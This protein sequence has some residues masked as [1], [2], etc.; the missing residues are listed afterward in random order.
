[1]KFDKGRYT[2]TRPINQPKGTWLK[3][4]KNFNM[5]QNLGSISS[6]YGFNLL[7]TIDVN[8]KCCG[9]IRLNPS[10]YVL[11]LAPI[12]TNILSKIERRNLETGEVKEVI[13]SADLNFSIDSPIYGTATQNYKN[14]SI[15]AFA[16]KSNPLR[17]INV[18]NIESSLSQS[19]VFPDFN[20]VTLDSYE[21]ELGGNLQVGSYF[22]VFRYKSN[23][24]QQTPYQF[25][26]NPIKIWKPTNNTDASNKQIK[27]FLTNLDTKFDTIEV[28]FIKDIDGEL[29]T[30][31]IKEITIDNRTEL[32]VS[33]SGNEVEQTLL[34]AEII[35]SYVAYDFFGEVSQHSNS[36]YLADL[37]GN[38]I[39]SDFQ[40]Q[41]NGIIVRYELEDINNDEI[42]EASTKGVSLPTFMPDEVYALYIA[43]R[44]PNGNKT[45]AYHIPG[46]PPT[47]NDLE[48]IETPESERTGGRR[49]RDRPPASNL[50]PRYT[51]L[52]TYSSEGKSLGYWENENEYYPNDIPKWGFLT[53][54]KVR[55]HRM[56]DYRE[57]VSGGTDPIHRM[58]KL[59]LTQVPMMEGATSYEI[60][61]A[62]RTDG[63]SLV[64]GYDLH[65][66]YAYALGFLGFSSID[67]PEIN[68]SNPTNTGGN[69]GRT[70]LDF[71]T[72]TDRLR[73]NQA[74][75]FNYLRLHCFDYLKTKSELKVDY[76]K[77]LN[78][79]IPVGIN[80]NRKIYNGGKV[81]NTSSSTYRT[82]AYI[83][84]V[85]K[86]GSSDPTVYDNLSNVQILDYIKV[87]QSS[88]KFVPESSIVD[89]IDNNFGEEHY[90]V[91]GSASF[92]PSTRVSARET[93]NNILTFSQNGE[94]PNELI[95]EDDLANGTETSFV[96]ELCSNKSD[97]YLNYSNQPL[98]SAGIIGQGSSIVIS[99]DSFLG[100]HL[101]FTG[102]AEFKNQ[103]LTVEEAEEIAID[104]KTKSKSIV[105]M[106]RRF[107]TYHSNDPHLR[108]YDPSNY[109]S[110]YSVDESLFSGP[111]APNY[112]K[113]RL[114]FFIDQFGR[115]S[116]SSDYIYNK[117]FSRLN[118]FNP[119]FPNEDKPIAAEFPY[120]VVKSIEFDGDNLY[121]NWFRFLVG[122][123]YDIKSN[124]G[125]IIKIVSKKERLLIHTEEALMQ[126]VTR[127]VLSTENNNITITTGELFR[128]APIEV[129]ESETGYAGLQNKFAQLNTEMGYIFVDVNQSKVFIYGDKMKELQN[130]GVSLEFN[131]ILNQIKDNPFNDEGIIIGYDNL[132][133]R[134][135]LTQLNQDT[136][137]TLSYSFDLN[138]W[139]FE[140]DYVPNF[141]MYTRKNRVFSLK[142]SNI[143][144]HNIKG[145]NTFYDSDPIECKFVISVNPEYNK[146]KQLS[147]LNWITTV[148]E[149][150]AVIREKTFTKIRIYNSYQDTGEI[151]LVSFVNLGDNSNIRK[152]KKDKNTWNFNAIRN[153]AEEFYNKNRLVDKY[154]IVELFYT[155]EKDQEFLIE[156][157]DFKLKLIN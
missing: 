74:N 34:L 146:D 42:S 58:I 8:Y 29:E 49:N 77:V 135:F 131:E 119:V 21:I 41:I 18:D 91:A 16:S 90:H 93:E 57:V 150:N 60:Y 95:L 47:P 45:P 154:F 152:D 98:I 157:I 2:N 83:D 73:L 1:M 87:K 153:V 123:F 99:G 48:L 94:N 112:R 31:K 26:N 33:Y 36:L 38:P 143:Y 32:V 86:V 97:L 129:I 101:F 110:Y 121:N 17:I 37:S 104:G 63:N 128:Q 67:A 71:E 20:T 118:E 12:G 92:T 15:V 10:S 30:V 148:I 44:F 156:D 75:Y 116:I 144:E 89:N 109:N 134:L 61:Y 56:P 132:F 100:C 23:T 78:K 120:R 145:S 127:D 59:E 151:E 62:K 141:F 149:N 137:F 54:Q 111:L 6:E 80:D 133:N 11:F 55:H 46:R 84:Y 122:D 19:L 113:E 136:S 35:Q 79:V 14:E 39:P 147:N 124:K 22:P 66:T 81:G 4:S 114:K 117:G 108:Q 28:A 52:S 7:D 9:V 142:Q 126:S 88:I 106:I 50:R 13:V 107:C 5:S 96:L 138:A 155:L 130:E 105:M 82:A 25:V 70:F 51:Y 103:T 115:N 53:G 43:Y 125:K 69:W 85:S 27:L 40:T 140:H 76:I 65:Q 139:A 64:K 72:V 102:G 24:G 68:L 3:G